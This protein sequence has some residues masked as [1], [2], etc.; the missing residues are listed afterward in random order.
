MSKRPS[1]PTGQHAAKASAAPSAAARSK[2]D[3][4]DEGMGE[5]EDAWDDE[6]VADEDLGEVHDAEEDEDKFEEL[7]EAGEGDVD[8]DEPEPIEDDERAPSPEPFLPTNKLEEGEF[9]QPDLTTY[10]LLHSFIPTWPS[11]SFDILRDD[12]G[13]E[14]RGYPVS[15][16][17]VAGTQAQDQS[18]NEVTIM[19]W[20][21]LGKTRKDDNGTFNPP[22]RGRSHSFARCD[23]PGSPLQPSPQPL[24]GLSFFEHSPF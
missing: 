12:G 22:E 23:Q 1:S 19:R 4:N 17:L 24:I 16:A 8:M 21:G 9:L 6:V 15:C 13:E 18:N 10:P 3:A 11:L 14:R 7:G 5:F 2:L 20:E